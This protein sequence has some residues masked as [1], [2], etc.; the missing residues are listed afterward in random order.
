MVSRI[1]HVAGQESL[2]MLLKGVQEYGESVVDGVE[3]FG[4]VQLDLEGRRLPRTA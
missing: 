3:G 2:Q 1:T 4:D